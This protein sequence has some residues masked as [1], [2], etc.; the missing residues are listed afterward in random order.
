MTLFEPRTAGIGSKSSAN[1][2][3]PPTYGAAAVAQWISMGLTFCGTRFESQ[4]QHLCLFQITFELR[5]E[6]DDNKL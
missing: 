6:K 5:C 1:R 2:A 4:V 3:Q